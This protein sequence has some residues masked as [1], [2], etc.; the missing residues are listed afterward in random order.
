MANTFGYSEEDFKLLEA[1]EAAMIPRGEK[2]DEIKEY[3]RQMGYTKIGIANCACVAKEAEI[4]AERFRPEFEAMVVGCKVGKIMRS[5][6]F[7]GDSKGAACNPKAQA[8]QLNEWGSHLNIV[9]ALCIGHDIMFQKH[10]EAPTTTLIVKDRAHKHNP[11]EELHS[12]PAEK[13]AAKE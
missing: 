11:M 5:E 6:M 13:Q 10:S 2:I 7:G 8:E 3:A 12:E 4:V 1:A 9:L